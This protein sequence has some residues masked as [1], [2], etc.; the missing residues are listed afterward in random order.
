[1]ELR[2]KHRS[3]SCCRGSV[4]A[5]CKTISCTHSHPY[6]KDHAKC[7]SILSPH[8]RWDRHKPLLLRPLPTF[9]YLILCVWDL[10]TLR[11]FSPEHFYSLFGEYFVFK[12]YKGA[13]LLCK[14]KYIRYTQA[15]L[16][17]PGASL[18]LPSLAQLYNRGKRKISR[19][20]KK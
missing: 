17:P 8:T 16:P 2:A 3:V 14:K 7:D 9:F 5:F 13:F 20:Q 19:V 6:H 15:S 11:L 4:H 12:A 1:M 10:H 18:Q